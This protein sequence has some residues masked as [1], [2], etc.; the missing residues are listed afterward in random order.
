MEMLVISS[1]L[2][3]DASDG[4]EVGSDVIGMDDVGNAVGASVGAVVGAAVV[5]AADGT[6][7]GALVSGLV[8]TTPCL[9]IASMVNQVPLARG[10]M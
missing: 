2:T 4:D 3:I 6:R 8:I 7:V 1:E 5:G 9:S 10:M